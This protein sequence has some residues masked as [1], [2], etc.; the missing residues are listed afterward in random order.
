ML[1]HFIPEIKLQPNIFER[2]DYWCGQLGYRPG[3]DGVGYQDFPIHQVKVESILA[4]EPRGKLL[5]IGCAFGYIVKRLHDKGFDAWGIDISQ[6]ALSQA[7]GDIKPYLK[8]GSCDNLPWPDKYFDMVV[9]FSVLEHTDPA[10]LPQA[11]SEIKRVAS[12]GIIA[13][14]PGDD[15]HFDED[16]THQT[17]QPLSWWRK[18]F[19]PQFEVRSDADEEWLRAKIPEVRIHRI[20]WMQGKVTLQDRVLDVGCAENP[21]W[22]GTNFNVLTLDSQINPEIQIFP[23]VLGEAENLPFEDRSFDIVAEGELLEHVPDPQRVLKEAVRVARKKV[24]ITVPWEHLWPPELKPFWNPGHVR[25]YAPQTLEDELKKVGLPFNIEEIRHGAWAW[26]GAEVYCEKEKAGELVKVNLGSFVDTIG[27]GWENWDILP[28]QQHITKGHK[29]K[30]WDVRRGLPLAD[31][32]V[33]LFRV[34]HLIEHLTLE[35]SHNL[36]RELYRTL[37]TGGLARISMPDARIIFMHYMNQDMSFFNQIQPPEYIQA[38]TQGEKLSRLLFSGDYSH[39]A[40]YNFE[41]LKNFLEQAG[42]ES[43]KI[44][45][46][47]PGFSHSEVMKSETE[48]QHIEVSLTVEALR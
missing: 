23:D 46:V 18:Q 8:H 10:M 37:K 42:F 33:D 9:T 29:F 13:V 3:P 35:E 47:S 25:F 48:D 44:Y 21:V 34:S 1:R 45:N 43:G 6:Y 24:I 12:R 16:I 27:Y 32:S 2:P 17:K 38:P 40:V 22:A 28:I 4:W 7:P 31:G 26:L 36:C 11:I 41:M 14:T 30:Q 5:D 15:P 20:Q 19:P 39:K